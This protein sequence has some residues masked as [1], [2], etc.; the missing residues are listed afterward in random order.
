METTCYESAKSGLD[1]NKSEDSI[2]VKNI[3]THSMMIIMSDGA[4]T[5]V[6]SRAW[7]GHITGNFDTAWLRS[8][9]DFRYGL[10]VIR[11]SFKPNIT[12]PTAL[13]KFLMEGSYAT[14]FTLLA[15]KKFSLFGSKIKLTFHCV[16]DVSLYVFSEEGELLYSFPFT[17][18][19]EFNNIP[20]LVR[21]SEK[22]QEKTPLKVLSDTFL[23]EGNNIIVLSTDAMSEFIFRKMKTKRGFRVIEDIMDCKDQDE[24]LQLVD[25][26]RNNENMKNDDVAV[27]ILKK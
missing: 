16:G 24:F 27:C 20:N 17:K 10:G 4:S 11:K 18:Q 7:S 22:L 13:R 12:R 26:Y 5:G 1:I 19:E 8:E 3:D 25:K 14:V 21:S 2:L 15:E 6:F 9:E 23:S